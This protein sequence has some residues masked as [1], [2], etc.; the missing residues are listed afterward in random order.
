M[1][2]LRFT[3]FYLSRVQLFSSVF[4]LISLVEKGVCLLGNSC[5]FDHGKDPVVNLLGIQGLA[6]PP[7]PMIQPPQSVPQIPELFGGVFPSS[8]IAN[9]VASLPAN[10]LTLDTGLTLVSGQQR[11]LPSVAELQHGIPV[12]NQPQ[13]ALRTIQPMEAEKREQR[14]D[15]AE[16]SEFLG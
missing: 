10:T 13:P 1:N 3:I 11:P 5:L 7:L 6:A 15:A 14:K 4:I 12:F 2:E 9:P 16:K 8:M